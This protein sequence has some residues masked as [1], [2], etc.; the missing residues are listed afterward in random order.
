M[1]PLSVSKIWNLIISSF[2]IFSRCANGMHHQINATCGSRP[3]MTRHMFAA[4][5]GSL[6]QLV[7]ELLWVVTAASATFGC[8]TPPWITLNINWARYLP[9]LPPKKCGNTLPSWGDARCH[10]SFLVNSSFSN[11]VHP[12]VVRSW[13]PH[14]FVPRKS[15]RNHWRNKVL[16]DKIRL[17]PNGI[18]EI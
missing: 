7:S 8:L 10:Y 12:N 16:Y 18:S 11:W 6:R 14:G 13:T 9:Y 5:A 17:N 1:L 15:R 3:I 4:A 2:L